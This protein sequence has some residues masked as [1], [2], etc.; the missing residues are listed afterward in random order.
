MGIL[1]QNSSFLFLA[2]VLFPNSYY[3]GIFLLYNFSEMK[4]NTAIK[5]KAPQKRKEG[6]L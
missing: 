6:S 4:Y 1:Q 3:F 5:K 2:F